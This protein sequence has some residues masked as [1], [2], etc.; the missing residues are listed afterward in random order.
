LFIDCLRHDRYYGYTLYSCSCFCLWYFLTTLFDSTSLK[1]ASKLQYLDDLKTAEMYGTH[2]IQFLKILLAKHP[3]IPIQVAWTV[4]HAQKTH[5]Y[6]TSFDGYIFVKPE[7][8]FFTERSKSVQL[9]SELL[10]SFIKNIFLNSCNSYLLF[11]LGNSIL[12]IKSQT[13]SG[14]VKP[15]HLMALIFYE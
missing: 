7:T 5:A 6:I 15:R 14:L 9:Q 8:H 4:K 2:V 12:V 11:K 10:T 1:F 3:H 13:F